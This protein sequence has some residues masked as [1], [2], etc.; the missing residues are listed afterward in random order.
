VLVL[1][2]LAFDSIEHI[3]R[4]I[5]YGIFIRYA[6][7]NGASLF[8]IMVYLHLGKAFYYNCYL[9]ASLWYSGIIIFILMM[10]IA[11][12]GYVLPF[13][14]M[15]YWGATV[16]TSMFSAIPLLGNDLV[17]LIWGNGC[18]SNATLSRF[19]SLHYLL[20]FLLCLLVIIHIIQLHLVGSSNPIGISIA[21]D[22][23]SFYP[24]Y[25]F[26]DMLGLVIFLI[27]MVIVISYYPY[28]LGHESNYLMANPLLTP[29]TIVPE[30]YF[31]PFYAILRSVPN[32][33][34]GIVLMFLAILILFALP[35]WRKPSDTSVLTWPCLFT[36]QAHINGTLFR[37]IHKVFYWLFIANFLLLTYLGMVHPNDTYVFISRIATILYFSYF[38]VLI[39]EPWLS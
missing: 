5:S 14:A 25:I 34:C 21:I 2:T 9:M 32:K 17:E 12:I 23:V 24:Y 26:K 10:A 28:V 20:P 7:S 39:T 22:K 8:L 31:L 19:Y 27:F 18:V 33:L 4:D 6:H 11:F 37:P 29:S 3:H 13:G 35:S 15:S 16:I 38:I 30:F 1:C 36:Q